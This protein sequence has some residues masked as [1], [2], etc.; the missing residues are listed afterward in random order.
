MEAKQQEILDN[1]EE[2]E[3]R[4]RL[5]PYRDLI[6]ELRRRNRTYREILQILTNHCQVRVSISTLHNFLRGQR[7]IDSKMKKRLKEK[8]LQDL[9][10]NSRD[11]ENL[12]ED[13]ADM[14]AVQQ[15][16]ATLKR[17]A[18]YLQIETPRFNYDPTQPLFLLPKL[19]K[20]K[21]EE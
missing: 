14:K 12:E 21:D 16:I 2:K 5:E 8:N 9:N 10:G 19:Q 6:L 15:R 17:H 4:S 20:V 11:R 3:P 1:L 18:P 7:R 13:S